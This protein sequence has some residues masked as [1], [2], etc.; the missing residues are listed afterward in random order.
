MNRDQVLFHLQEAAEELNRTIADFERDAEFSEPELTVA[1]QHLYHHLDTA[2]NS[3]AA[4]SE[5]IAAATDQDFNRSTR[6]RAQAVFCKHQRPP[7]G[8]CER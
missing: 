3:R 5:R 4:D 8:Y 7:A 2:W 1:M 6:T